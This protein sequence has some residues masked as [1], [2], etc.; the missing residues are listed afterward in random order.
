ME[1]AIAIAL[2]IIAAWLI[3]E[4]SRDIKQVIYN[5]IVGLVA[6]VVLDMLG[7]GLPINIVTFIIVAL[8]GLLGLIAI[9]V[10]HFLG[11]MF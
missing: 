4:A 2:S 6:M 9:I 1:T 11:I 3:F 7:V 8:T 10:L 5:S